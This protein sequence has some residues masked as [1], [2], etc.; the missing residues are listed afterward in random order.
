MNGNV[1]AV[2]LEMGEWTEE[3]G[4]ELNNQLPF[5]VRMMIEPC[6]GVSLL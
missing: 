1:W 4:T 5:C 6:F 2:G 3:E